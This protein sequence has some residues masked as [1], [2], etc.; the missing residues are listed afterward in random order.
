M[1]PICLGPFASAGEIS[2]LGR[3]GQL[4]SAATTEILPDG[5]RAHCN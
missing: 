1:P 4:L 5:A 2:V 3:A